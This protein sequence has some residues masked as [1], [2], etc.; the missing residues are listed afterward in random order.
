MGGYKASRLG[1][2]V[3]KVGQSQSGPGPPEAGRRG[4][5]TRAEE[6]RCAR[7]RRGLEEP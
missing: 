1:E 3:R 5:T 7:K 4:H 2:N 6:G